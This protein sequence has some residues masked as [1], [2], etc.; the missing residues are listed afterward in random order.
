[1][2]NRA[3]KADERHLDARRIRRLRL[4]RGLTLEAAAAGIGISERTLRRYESGEVGIVVLDGAR[5]SR[6]R[7]LRDLAMFYRVDWRELLLDDLDAPQIDPVQARQ[8]I[9]LN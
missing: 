8:A 1:M 4:E 5:V 6:I 9:L 2:S 3:S 7:N